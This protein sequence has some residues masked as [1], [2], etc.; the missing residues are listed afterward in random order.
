MA[1]DPF[2]PGGKIRSKYLGDLRFGILRAFLSP[3]SIAHSK[4]DAATVKKTED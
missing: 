1:I 3:R 2:T 4:S